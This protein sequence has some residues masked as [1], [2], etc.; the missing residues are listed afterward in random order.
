[1]DFSGLSLGGPPPGTTSGQLGLQMG[2][3]RLEPNAWLELD[4]PLMELQREEKA[5]LMGE[6][7][8]EL[9]IARPDASDASTELL[10]EVMAAFVD[11]GFDPPLPDPALHPLDAAARLVRE[12]FV[13]H[14]LVDERLIV[15]AGSVCFPT[16][17]L[18]AEKIGHPLDVVHGPVPGYE[19]DLA[20]RVDTFIGRLASG[21][22]VWRR[23]W[24][25]MPTNRLCLPG[26]HDNLPLGTRPE[27]MWLRTERQTLRRLPTTGAV[28]FT[29][30]IDVEPLHT[31]AAD[32]TNSVAL[33]ETIENLAPEFLAYKG[34]TG[35][36]E[37]IAAYLRAG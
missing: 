3:R 11:G 14:T 2:L 35:V 26:Y 31:V 13:V 21:P 12:D 29:I 27:E 6:R 16:R 33:A 22:G 28:I 23:N 19:R 9:F 25:I 1:M 20:R 5:T 17:W 32:A 30:G 34:L 15:S 8:S 10:A 18:L 36:G 24:S 37:R 4:H 7:P